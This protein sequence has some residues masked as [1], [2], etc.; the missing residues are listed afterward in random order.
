ML[1]I[2]LK[3]IGRKHDPSFRIVVTE[4]TA[5]PKGKY[6]EAVG[7]YNSALKQLKLNSDRIKYWL[8]VG[9][10]PTVVVN[11]ILVKEG[12]INTPKKRAHSTRD[13]KKGESKEDKPK[14]VIQ[15]E[16]A[17]KADDAKQVEITS[18]EVDTKDEK[19]EV[20]EDKKEVASEE[21]IVGEG[22]VDV[23]KEV[24]ES[25]KEEEIENS[26]PVVDGIQEKEESGVSID[27]GDN[28]DKNAEE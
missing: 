18:Q 28:K 5:P 2:R 7:F 23:N 8:G 4:A 17:I 19:E 6:K 15:N 3:R 22:A 12:I 13:R 10:T 27:N 21:G 14:V 11:N 24:V 25:K 20:V 16:P 9:A 26:S 1:K